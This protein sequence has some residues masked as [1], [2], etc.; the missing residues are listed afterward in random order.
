[1]LLSEKN[2]PSSSLFE[3]NDCDKLVIYVDVMGVMEG[4]AVPQVFIPELVEYYKN[5]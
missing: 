5:G 1:L 2:F 4:D 3:R